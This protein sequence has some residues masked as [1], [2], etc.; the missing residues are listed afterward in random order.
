MGIC[1]DFHKERA[2]N[3][4]MI[5]YKVTCL[6]TNKIYIGKTCHSLTR[7]KCEHLRTARNDRSH[8]CFHKA[9]LKY[10]E[11]SFVWEVLDK[12]MF[13]DLLMDLEKFYIARYNCKIPNGYNMTDGGEGVAG[14]RPSL[15][16]RARMSA[17]LKGNRHTL[18]H[19]LSSEHLAK[20]SASHMGNTARLGHHPTPET[21]A[22][23]SVANKGR[24]HTPESIAKIVAAKKNITPE[25]RAKLSAASK[26]RKNWLGRKHSPETKAKMSAAAKGKKNHNFGK[27]PW[28]WRGHAVN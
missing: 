10:G 8:S 13:S 3:K 4:A 11:E 5:I 26:G 20:L 27:H 19:K 24:R 25:T 6:E 7:R 14:W 23:M 17:A 15:E 28:N 18:G 2:Y 1:V 21:L 9:I 16:T 22:K 12:V